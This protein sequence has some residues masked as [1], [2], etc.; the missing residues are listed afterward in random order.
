M[1]DE[2]VKWDNLFGFSKFQVWTMVPAGEYDYMFGTVNGLVGHVGLARVPK[3]DVL[4]KTAYRYW[5]NDTWA[6]VGSNGATP[7]RRRDGRGT[8]GPSR[9]GPRP[10]Q[11][12]YLDPIRGDIVLQESNSP[13]IRWTAPSTAIDTAEYP[14]ANGSFIHPWSTANELYFTM[15]EW[16]SY[17]VYLVKA[18]LRSS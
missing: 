9:R 14:K 17:S 4:N 6:P 16:D 2:H 15:S 8:V 5:V 11:M 13:Q 10:W 18:E 7:H 12:T 3:A 1:E